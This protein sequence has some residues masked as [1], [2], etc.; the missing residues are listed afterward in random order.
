MSTTSGHVYL[1][2]YCFYLKL[3]TLSKANFTFIQNSKFRIL[4]QSLHQIKKSENNQMSTIYL[5]FDYTQI[6][7]FAVK[8]VILFFILENF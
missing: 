2:Y 5:L 8:M 1:K 4:Y 3:Q 6:G 7:M